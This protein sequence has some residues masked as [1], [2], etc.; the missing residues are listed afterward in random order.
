MKYDFDKVI[1]RRRTDSNKWKKYGDEVI[2]LWVADMD[3][4]SA[5]PIIQ[6]LHKRVDHGVFGYTR[7]T[8]ELRNAI[9]E[10]LKYTIGMWGKRRL[11]SCLAW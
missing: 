6:A 8:K 5:E 11:S 3:F 10:R 4:I 2:P 9:Q 7:P 1:D